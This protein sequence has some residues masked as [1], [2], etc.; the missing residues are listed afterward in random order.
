[1]LERTVRLQSKKA[2][3]VVLVS[4]LLVCILIKVCGHTVDMYPTSVEAIWG[5]WAFLIEV[6]PLTVTQL[7]QTNVGS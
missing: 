2:V 6:A 5:A 4:I 7:T 3:V 1:M